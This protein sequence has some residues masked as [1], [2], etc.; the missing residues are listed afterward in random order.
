M[1]KILVLVAAL[2]LSGCG[3]DTGAMPL[4][5]GATWQYQSQVGLTSSVVDVSVSGE[6]P[7]GKFSGF[8]LTS[9]H[10][11][12]RL[13]WGQGVLWASQLGGT[14]FEP[15]IPIL[16][17]IGSKLAWAGTMRLAGIAKKSKASLTVTETDEKVGSQERKARQSVLSLEAGPER[18]EVTTWF[19]V[20]VGI[21]RQEQR[22]GEMLTN[23]LVYLSGPEQAIPS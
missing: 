9:S 12:A 11:P 13:A 18:T 4:R 14:T 23:R 10:C 22:A 19:V 1:K 3:Q 7:V 20:G 17:P 5:R 21:V 8:E 16:A 6:V 15:P 2:L